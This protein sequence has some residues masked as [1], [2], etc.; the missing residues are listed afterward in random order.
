METF[1]QT[2]AKIILSGEHSVLYGAPA[3][4]MAIDFTTHCA[5][6][7]FEQTKSDEHPFI[8]I[9]LTD[10]EQK[11]AFPFKIWQRRVINIESRY[12]LYEK[13]ATSIH[14]VLQQP[15]DLILVTLQQFHNAY[16]LKS[17][18][19][20]IKIKSHAH[21]GKGLGSSASVIVSLLHGL[22]TQHGINVTE[23]DLLWLAQRVE[24]RQHGHSSGIDPTTVLKGGLLRYQQGS[25]LQQ[26]SAQHFNAWLIDTGKPASTTGQAVSQVHHHFELNDPIWKTFETVTNEIGQAWQ[27]QDSERLRNAIKQNQQLLEQLG[28]VP[29]RV[30]TFIAT[31]N[32]E[33]NIAAK[34]CGAGSS[35]GERAGFLICIASEAPYALCQEFGYDIY[36]LQFSETG[37]TCVNHH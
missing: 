1:C 35:H 14:R 5:L 29:E 4:S 21:T 23:A 9:E 25:P 15:V 31:L 18:H 26:L 27:C 22:F 19:W 32:H 34:I 20:R 10:Y 16:H 7:F 8:E 24:S 17:G 11:Y 33:E 12:A 2:P 3:L 37:S 28:I 30:Q 6:Q 36:P 13:N